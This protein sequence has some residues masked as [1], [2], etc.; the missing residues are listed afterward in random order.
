MAKTPETHITD[1]ELE[2]LS[3]LWQKGSASVKDVHQVLRAERDTGYTTTLK[4]MQQM[5]EKGLL[6]RDDTLRQHIYKPAIAQEKV[7]HRFMDRMM[8]VLFNDSAS[9]LILQALGQYK[10]T[11]GE[12]DQIVALIEK[13]KSGQK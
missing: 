7:Q 9:D 3:L 2:I 8:K 11:A 6:S 10:A 12:L 13:H 5:H 4:Q 1:T